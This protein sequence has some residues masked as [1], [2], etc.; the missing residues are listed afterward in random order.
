MAVIVPFLE[1]VERR[2]GPDPGR[3]PF[4]AV[5][6]AVVPCASSTPLI[7]NI[8]CDDCPQQRSAHCEDCVVT[9][10]LAPPDRFATARCPDAHGPVEQR[11]IS[12]VR[13]AAP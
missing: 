10:L 7:V 2:A 3:H 8:S 5:R 4:V 13:R 11:P 1:S 9:H 6:G 12:L